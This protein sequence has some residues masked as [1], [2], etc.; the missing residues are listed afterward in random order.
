[1]E[2][3]N[4]YTDGAFSSTREQGGWAFVVVQGDKQLHYDCG[5]VK[6]TTNNRMELQA[7]MEATKWLQDNFIPEAMIVSDSMYCIG[8]LTKGWKRKKNV[9]MW[10]EMDALGFDY[11]IKHVKGHSGDKWN[12][13][14]DMWAVHARDLVLE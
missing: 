12:D 14:C 7:I 11:G 3:I 8:C 2:K 9:D 10:A 6:D 4:V 13:T 5:G 1:M